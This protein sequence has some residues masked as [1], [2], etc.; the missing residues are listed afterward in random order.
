MRS[1][2]LFC[3]FFAA[4]TFF[5]SPARS[6]DQNV[7]VVSE[8]HGD[9]ARRAGRRRTKPAQR[10]PN[11]GTTV[12][13][14]QPPAPPP[15][16]SVQQTVVV[17]P[18][19]P[20]TPALACPGC[21]RLEGQ[22]RDLEQKQRD[23]EA[24]LAGQEKRLSLAEELLSYQTLSVGLGIGIPKG[25]GSYRALLQVNAGP[26]SG[27]YY[28]TAGYGVAV[29]VPVKLWMLRIKPIGFGI[30]K[31]SNENKPMLVSDYHRSLDFMLVSGIETRVWKGLTFNFELNWFIPLSASTPANILEQKAKE[32]ADQ[33]DP[34]D[35][36]SLNTAGDTAKQGVDTI[37][38]AYKR[39]WRTPMIVIGLHWVF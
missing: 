22:V 23:L 25:E 35:P 7:T 24:K 37:A 8:D 11:G 2:M 31:N 39:A 30:F 29:V 3:G 36:N 12:I 15:P 4:L 28:V 5:P 17:N 21:D 38:D 33:I 20:Q 6:E 19:C 26:V 1:S 27:Y 13:I 32:G 18:P 34:N 16:A 10:P 14:E 9:I